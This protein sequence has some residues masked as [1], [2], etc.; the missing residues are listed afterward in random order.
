MVSPAASVKTVQSVSAKAV[1]STQPSKSPA[2]ESVIDSIIQEKGINSVVTVDKPEAGKI[3]EVTLVSGQ[4]YEFNFA[5]KDVATFTHKDG[6]LTLHF[7]D[8]AS[9]VVRDFV[10][11]TAD[12]TPA[13]LKF[14][15][16]IDQGFLAGIVKVTDAGEQV[17][18][19][20]EVTPKAK[21]KHIENVSPENVEP[22]A[23]EEVVAG[24]KHDVPVDGDK[25]E[26]EAEKAAEVEPAAGE[27]SSSSSSSSGSSHGGYGF[28]SSFDAQ[29][30]IPLNDVGPINPTSLNYDLLQTLDER[31]I[32]SDVV[33]SPVEPL[34]PV[35]EF[36]DQQVY[37]DG[38]V[39]LNLFAAPDSS[40]GILKI[41]I[42]GISPGWLVDGPGTFDAGAGTWT[43]IVPAGLPFTG[44]PTFHPPADSD[45]DLGD[46]NIIVTENDPSSG[47]SGNV[48]G[49]F[50]IIVDAVADIP[51]LD[52]HNVSGEE[53][54]VIPFDIVTSVSDTDGSELIETVIVSGLPAGVTLTAG[55]YDSVLDKWFL[56]EADLVGLGISV[57]TGVVGNYHLTIE[58]I[59]FEQFLSGGEF[60]L[61]NNHASAFEDVVLC[62]KADDIPVIVSPSL[63][64]LDE[65]NLAPTVS[66]TDQVVVDFGSDAPGQINGNGTYFIGALTSEGVPVNVIFDAS[67]NT[68]SGQAAGKEIFNLV[69]SADGNYTFTLLNPLDHLDPTNADDSLVLEFGVTATDSEGDHA[70]G[71]ITINVHDDGVVAYDDPVSFDSS[72]S[73]ISGNVVSN[74]DLSVDLHNTVTKVS[75][76]G[77]EV[78]VDSLTGATIAGDHGVLHINADGSYTYSLFNSFQYAGNAALTDNFTYTLVDGDGDYDAAVLAIDVLPGSLVVGQNINDQEGSTTPHLVG[79]GVEEIV[80]GLGSDILVGDAG[81]SF[82]E[83]Q[84]QDYN[85]VFVLDV[86]GSMAYP[87]GGSTKIDLLRDAVQNLMNEFA[88]YDGG[89]IKVHFVPFATNAQTAG[90]FTVTDAAGLSDALSYLD[91]LVANGY[92]NYEAPMQSAIDWLQSSEPLGGNAITTTYFISDGQPNRYIDSSGN[93]ATGNYITALGETEGV[94]GSHEINLLHSLSD[95]VKAIG[96][97]VGKTGGLVL[98][99]VDSSGH[100]LI[101]DE[102]SDLSVA[103]SGTAPLEKLN[104]TGDDVLVG[105]AGGDILFGD[106]LFTDDLAFMHGLVLEKAAGW[107]VFERLE[108]GESSIN[109]SWSRLDTLHYINEHASEL[110]QESLDAHGVGR[111]GGDDRLSGGSGNDLIFGQEGNDIIHGGLGNDDIYGGSGA[112]RFL[113]ETISEGVD[114]IH[115]FNVSQG[116]KLDFSTLLSVFDP[117]IDNIHDFVFAT[118]ISGNT[119]I[120]VD[121]SGSGNSSGAIEVAMLTG[122]S[123][124]DLDLAVTTEHLV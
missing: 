1:A 115:D 66:T 59:A 10:V 112:D 20:E 81:G 116:D 73:D 62:I 79:G 64:V 22:A 23:G 14:T 72:I 107:E 69:I 109:S 101:I 34:R 90:T 47:N 75:F 48:S 6:S 4:K 60:D 24:Q 94:D 58:S 38:S 77:S 80:G 82:V 97:E 114:T 124:L 87:S 98:N 32:S 26:Q 70:D 50:D 93:V 103:L 31:F 57:P 13:I 54:T 63:A 55:T 108:A 30:V 113:F 123:G 37:E 122:V 119:V 3:A 84:S 56:S 36:G 61:T 89:E 40:S 43:I 65:T 19:V 44:G 8:G 111:A 49:V 29:G 12:E 92:T 110:A 121:T 104:A 99:H 7:S 42:T 96:I 95:E 102:A 68:Y 71:V 85:F 25:A 41:V 120:S 88:G 16:S 21:I 117:L 74:D 45:L 53:G 33:S 17:F 46:L 78:L 52:S 28:Q 27:S 2:I 39:S 76:N 86:S 11:A 83:D 105:G 51:V 91:H 106:V 118:E 18:E 35:L 67:T 15:N 5:D 100:A 9:I